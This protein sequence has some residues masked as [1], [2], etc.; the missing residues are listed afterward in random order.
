[1][2]R[3]YDE[4]HPELVEAARALPAPDAGATLAEA[5]AAVS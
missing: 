5:F 1:V 3:F 2:T 4:R